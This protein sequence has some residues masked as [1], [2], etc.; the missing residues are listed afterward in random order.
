MTS[1]RKI[2][3]NR[4]N[5]KRS[6]GPKTEVGKAKSSGNARKHGLSRRCL[7]EG[8]VSSP[9]VRSAI[10]EGFEQ[11]RNLLDVDNLVRTNLRLGRIR[12]ARLDLLIALLE[13]PSPKLAKRLA[14][15]ERYERPARA[16]QRRFLRR[17]LKPG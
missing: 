6:T 4:Q 12:Q 16:A 8:A 1:K 7:E 2:E 3:A 10:S 9:L 13:C 11:Q 5:A 14:G 15:L 17:W